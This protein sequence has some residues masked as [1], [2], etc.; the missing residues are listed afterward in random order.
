MFDCRLI[1]DYLEVS[2]QVL[3]L[4]MDFL[5]LTYILLLIIIYISFIFYGISKYG[6]F[7]LK[8]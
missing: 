3:G 2:V 8:H 4:A 1:V 7:Y 5:R 6:T